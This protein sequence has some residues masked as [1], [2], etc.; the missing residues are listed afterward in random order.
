MAFRILNDEEISLLD[1]NQRK[2]YENE[3]DIYLKRVAFVE[4]LEALENA[5]IPPYEPKLQSIAVMNGI[6]VKPFTRPEYRLSVC[7]PIVKPDLHVTPFEMAEPIIPVLPKVSKGPDVHVEHIKKVEFIEPKLPSISR[8]ATPA[9]CFEKAE[10][11]YPDL[12]EAYKLS[13]SVKSYKGLGEIKPNLPTV[14]K[15]A[16]Q[17]DFIFKS[18]SID[19]SDI[20]A[21]IPDVFMPSI[22]LNPLVMQKKAWHN[23]PEV[24]VH[25]AEIRD[26]RKPE[27]TG[28]V[29]PEVAKPHV[30]VHYI[31]N[32]KPIQANL[33]ELCDI[34]QVKAAFK[35][36][37][38][39]DTKLPAVVKPSVNVRPFKK[40]E[41]TGTCLPETPKISIPPMDYSKPELQVAALPSIAKLNSGMKTF[42]R[43]E[44][45]NPDLPIV[46]KISVVTNTFKKP[47]LTRSHI[48]ASAPPSV[49]VKLFEKIESKSDGLPDRIVVNIPDAYAK[50]RQLFPTINDDSGALEGTDL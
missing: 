22:E 2:Q 39:S 25:F 10:R 12:P 1:D 15:P 36:P 42:E 43:L 16:T 8:P 49:N 31:K 32:E 30:N 41:L 9:K 37:E 26:Y 24:S 17:T 34:A 44:H 5:T 23:L 3:L 27:Q 7:D 21:R 33:P 19:S 11:K 4:R 40:T 45:K 18:I 38:K 6:E 50:L 13:V 29:L 48:V 46:P 35:K 14:M 47:E 20:K 28:V